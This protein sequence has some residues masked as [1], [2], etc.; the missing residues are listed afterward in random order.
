MTSKSLSQ[1]LSQFALPGTG[2][3]YTAINVADVLTTELTIVTG[4]LDESGSTSP[5]AKDLEKCV[6]TIIDSLRHSP[7]ADNLMYRHCHFGTYFREVHGYKLLQDINSGDYNGCYQSGGSTALYDSM[8]NVFRA[9]KDYGEQCQKSKRIANGLVFVLT[10]GQD[11]GSTLRINDAR[12]ALAACIAGE[13]LESLITILIGVNPDANIQQSLK[14]MANQTGFTQYIPLT[15]V[16]ESTLA[17]LAKFISHSISSQSQALG[18][19]GPSQTLDP[20]AAGL[21]NNGSLTF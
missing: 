17:K 1:G 9:V 2:F 18:S 10:D 15:D 6:K 11:N 5:F 16:S 8:D 14:D 7:R 13:S 3:G 19:G 21:P 12:N 4:L 20:N